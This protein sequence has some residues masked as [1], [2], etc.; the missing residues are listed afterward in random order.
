[1]E[2]ISA[3]VHQSFYL[4]QSILST[5]YMWI[6]CIVLLEKRKAFSN[7][8]SNKINKLYCIICL[9][10]VPRRMTCIF[11]VKVSKEINEH[12]KLTF[13]MLCEMYLDIIRQTNYSNIY[14]LQ[15]IILYTVICLLAQITTTPSIWMCGSQT[16]LN[17][18]TQVNVHLLST[19]LSGI[20]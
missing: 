6:L 5:H 7:Y 15:N 8:L 1:M 14:F 17:V 4:Q 20:Q 18:S 9:R 19:L 11:C 12:N 16:L 3:R 13:W 10:L 2:N